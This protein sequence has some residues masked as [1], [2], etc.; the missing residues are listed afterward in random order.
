VV[1]K[2]ERKPEKL[3][4]S[5]LSFLP[6]VYTGIRIACQNENVGENFTQKLSKKNL[7]LF[8]KVKKAH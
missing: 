5:T 6:V 3:K 4:C 7:P 2:A 1:D 8:A